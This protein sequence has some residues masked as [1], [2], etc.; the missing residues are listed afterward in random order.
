MTYK[1]YAV[2]LGLSNSTGDQTR[3]HEKAARNAA[4]EVLKSF[5]L[6]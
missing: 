3:K 5:G 2:K 1:V 4:F 6:A